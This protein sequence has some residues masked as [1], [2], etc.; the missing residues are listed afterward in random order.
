MVVV[1]FGEARQRATGTPPLPL[2]VEQATCP[3]LPRAPGTLPLAPF[4]G[5]LGKLK[6]PQL[7]QK[8]LPM[9]AVSN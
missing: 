7:Q 4:Y 5:H 9:A 8:D 6:G 3:A 1:S 2:L